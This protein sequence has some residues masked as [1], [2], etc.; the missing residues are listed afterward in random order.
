MS[1]TKI[2]SI[3]INTGIQLAGV[4]TVSTLHVG[5]GVTL[6]SDGDVFATGISTFSEDIKVGSGVTISPD[7][8]GFYTGVVTA[9]TFSG[10]LA[11][12]NLT[13]ALPAVSGA[14]ITNLNASNLASG[15]VPTARLGSGTASS[16]TFLR[17]D[18]TFQTVNTDLV[19]DT[20]P[21]LGG[22][23]D[24]GG[25]SII[26]DDN[27]K[28]RLGNNNDLEIYHNGSTNIID[29]TQSHPI[30]FRYG[31]NEQFFVGNAEFKGADNKKIKLG[32]G[33]DMQLYHDGTTNYIEC[34]ASNFAIRVNSGN[35]I[36]VNGTSG[37]VVM[38]GSSG[39]NFTWDNS[40]AYLNL[41]DNA[42]LTLGT[43][44]DLF[45]YHNGSNTIFDQNGTGSLFFQIGGANKFYV[46]SGGA[47][48]V[49]SLYGDDNNKIELGDDQD[50]KIYHNSSVSYITSTSGALTITQSANNQHI[51]L[52]KATGGDIRILDSSDANTHIFE[53][54]GALRFLGSQ[55]REASN[56]NS[57]C[58]GGNNSLDFS[59]SEY[60]YFR[61]NGVERARFQMSN[62]G[63]FQIGRS[64][65]TPANAQ[66]G[67]A[68]SNSVCAIQTISD[69]SSGHEHIRFNNTNGEVGRI[70]TSGGGTTYYTSSDYR[71]KEND[72]A[73]SDGVTRVKQLR[74]IKFNWKANPSETVEGFFAHEVQAIV[75]EAVD[76]S[77][78]QV[79]TQADID[80]EK[81]KQHELGDPLYQAYDASRLVPLLTAAIKELITRVENLE[82][83]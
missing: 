65:N 81:F 14:N 25:N 77:K 21:Q 11:A 56:S 75:P 78:D 9:T 72:V 45:M 68:V 15:T 17:G 73:I 30:S 40:T 51:N 80:E 20:S 18:S 69:G 41:N 67:V 50:L 54:G 16:S 83:A 48:F 4:T 26:M 70:T 71:L 46:Q 57:I 23:L 63:Y 33:D 60:M 1:L 27:S 42:R 36:E 47:Q 8:D 44:N 22:N 24:A 7:G 5:S 49:G 2:G 61:T 37:D 38:Q 10:A 62:N 39:K 29:G 82:S 64:G 3:G 52:K 74:P 35:R 34:G 19:S 32:T 53:T 79:V 28:L 55:T 58:S 59:G 66:L 13:G 12:S 43:G 6:S 31:G 76:R